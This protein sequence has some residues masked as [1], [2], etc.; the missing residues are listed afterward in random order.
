[1]IKK[2]DRKISKILSNN[3][4]ELTI[5][6]HFYP[7]DTRHVPEATICASLSSPATWQESLVAVRRR[8]LRLLRRLL[9]RTEHG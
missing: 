7:L 5:S 8:L 2:I 9:H 6:Q 1:M 3:Y 4:L